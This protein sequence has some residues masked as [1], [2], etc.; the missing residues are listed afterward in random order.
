MSREMTSGMAAAV[1]AG[2]VRPALLAEI[3]TASGAVRVWTGI[4]ELTWDGKAF[5]GVGTFGG[6]SAVTETTDL[7]ANGVRFQLSG[8]PAELVAVALSDVRQGLPASLW[9]ACFDADMAMI[10]DP[11]LVFSGRTDV[12]DLDDS[13]GAAAVGVTAE[14]RL[15]D[16]DRPRTRRYT[17]EDQRLDDPTDRGFDYVAGLQEKEFRFGRA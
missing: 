3:E 1:A 11:L 4:G 2:T 9:L 12:P 10:A 8:V 13:G 6:V 16:L 5:Q 17:P 15:I 14:S 7:S